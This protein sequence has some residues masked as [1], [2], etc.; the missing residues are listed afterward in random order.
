V[1][2]G[3]ATF[4]KYKIGKTLQVMAQYMTNFIALIKKNTDPYTVCHEATVC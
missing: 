1:Q 2:E 4:A 3:E